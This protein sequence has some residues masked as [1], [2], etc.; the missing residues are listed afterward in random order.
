MP[1]EKLYSELLTNP[2][3]TSDFL[4]RAFGH[5]NPGGRL[6]EEVGRITGQ[7]KILEIASI[8]K[9]ATESGKRP[10]PHETR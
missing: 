7:D 8:L 6:D 1:P 4:E 10:V 5:E 3:I 2:E 9:E